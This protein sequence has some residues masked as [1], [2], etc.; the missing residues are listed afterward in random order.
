[1]RQKKK[2]LTKPK[3]IL[4]ILSLSN[5]H[6]HVI[7]TNAHI[8]LIDLSIQV[9]QTSIS[10]QHM[11][12]AIHQ[13]QKKIQISNINSSNRDPPQKDY[14][15]VSTIM[16]AAHVDQ[17]QWRSRERYIKLLLKPIVQRWT[18]PS[19]S[20]WRGSWSWRGRYLSLGSNGGEFPSYGGWFWPDFGVSD[21]RAAS[22]TRCSGDLYIWGF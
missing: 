3:W 17:I 4:K 10:R 13:G 8:S 11:H 18:T 7:P 2:G 16:I 12:L 21:L 19:L 9:D 15:Y 1:M 6:P 5:H 22:V 20:W 14:K